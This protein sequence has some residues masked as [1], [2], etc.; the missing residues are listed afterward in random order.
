[1]TCACVSVSDWLSVCTSECLP[2]A[3]PRRNARR[4]RAHPSLALI[5]SIKSRHLYIGTAGI[6][7]TSLLLLTRPTGKLRLLINVMY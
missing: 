5:H 3:L 6:V 1:M 7:S 4:K 2:H